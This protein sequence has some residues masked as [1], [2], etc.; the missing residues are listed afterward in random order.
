[1]IRQHLGCNVN[2]LSGSGNPDST[3]R[4]WFPPSAFQLS[5]PCRHFV[6][7]CQSS[8]VVG[9]EGQSTGVQPYAGLKS[10]LNI[11]RVEKRV[12]HPV[13]FR[14][15][16]C[17]KAFSLLIVVEWLCRTNKKEAQAALLDLPQLFFFWELNINSS[18]PLGQMWWQ[19]PQLHPPI[20]SPPFLFYISLLPCSNTISVLTIHQSRS[21]CVKL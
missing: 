16:S 6:Y 13:L 12:P 21:A 2:C 3:S 7:G 19:G 5:A 20:I 15:L 18:F 10:K 11:C 9:W 17:R 1:M 8:Q 14:F 4:K